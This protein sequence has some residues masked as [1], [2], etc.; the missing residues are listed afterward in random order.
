MSSL[1]LDRSLKIFFT[2]FISIVR[3]GV[4]KGLPIVES[5]KRISLLRSH[6]TVLESL[7]SHGSSCSITNVINYIMDVPIA[8]GEINANVLRTYSLAIESLKFD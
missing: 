6:G 2:D 7:P 1:D 4:L 8:S 5:H 3:R